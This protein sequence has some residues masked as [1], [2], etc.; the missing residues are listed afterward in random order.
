MHVLKRF[1]ASLALLL[2]LLINISCGG[3]AGEDHDRETSISGQVISTAGVGLAGVPIHATDGSGC[4]ANT[5]ETVTGRDGNYVIVTYDRYVSGYSGGEVAI[6]PVNSP[7]GGGPEY[8]FEPSSRKIMV[9]YGDRLEGIDFL[10]LR[11]FDI[12]GRVTTADGTALTGVTVQLTGPENCSVATGTD[13]S[14]SFLQLREGNYQITPLSTGYIF[15]PSDR[16]V[17]LTDAAISMQDF[18]AAAI[19]HALSGT[20]RVNGLGI[21]GIPVRLLAPGGALV[22]TTSGAAGLFRF[23][24]L[25]P[26]DYTI[27]PA[28]SAYAYQ[29]ESQPVTLGTADLADVDFNAIP[30]GRTLSGRVTTA[31]GQGVAGI[32]L[33]L[34]PQPVENATTKSAADGSFSFG[35]I[36]GNAYTLT[37]GT[38]CP[39]FRFSPEIRNP[40]VT[41]A[42]LPAQ[43]FVATYLSDRKYVISGRVGGADGTGMAGIRVGLGGT[44]VTNVTTDSAGDFLFANLPNGEYTVAPVP[45]DYYFAPKDRAVSIC[46]GQPADLG[47]VERTLW[48]KYGYARGEARAA[49]ELGDGY[50]FAGGDAGE[51]ILLRTD[52]TGEPV[53]VR[54]LTGGVQ[55]Q[56]ADLAA[57]ADGGALLAGQ[58]IGFADSADGR[59]VRLN[60]G[61]NILWQQAVGGASVDFFNAAVPYQGGFAAAGRLGTEVWVLR[62]G[63]DGAVV[64]QKTYGSGTVAALATTAAGNLIAAVGPRLLLL[65]TAGD[66]IWSKSYGDTSDST[67]AIKNVRELP[68]G[69]F[70]AVGETTKPGGWIWALRLDASGDVLWQKLLAMGNGLA[71]TG[72][73]S[74]A[75]G[76]LIISGHQEMDISTV[77]AWLLQLRIN[78]TPVAL[79]TFGGWPDRR[80]L[81]KLR[82]TT[83]GRLLGAGSF[84]YFGTWFWLLKFDTTMSNCGFP[85]AYTGT[86]QVIAAPPAVDVPASSD[87]T[88]S[89]TLTT[90]SLNELAPVNIQ[91][92]A[93]Q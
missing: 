21:A 77:Q 17:L 15:S 83:D 5:W 47:F 24:H 32:T 72:G 81:L 87:A 58:G 39:T 29:P 16:A 69:E 30:I 8:A 84:S 85:Q 22:S 56:A 71:V 61:G 35:G 2:P 4:T 37:P 20:I 46:N 1:F 67:F 31:N 9:N 75:D 33:T 55:L 76:S 52:N 68:G 73:W 43:D 63:G 65:N 13:G 45:A 57:A 88:A 36:Y 3:G 10:A 62:L 12:T 18:L 26:G 23:D 74:A 27:T 25:L 19:P 64:W 82:G 86:D 90:A 40:L 42:D 28:S 78:G 92:G 53:W 14:F 48:S 6:I 91:G 34:A 51:Q 70:F 7:P 49:V 50:L 41:D 54:R 60:G 59:L 38:A 89:V 80:H 66:I 44:V 79:R 11:Q 93:C